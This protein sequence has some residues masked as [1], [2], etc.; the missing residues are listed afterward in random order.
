MTT[1]LI[2]RDKVLR[3]LDGMAEWPNGRMSFRT[4]ERYSKAELPCTTTLC[5]PACCAIL[6]GATIRYF[7][8]LL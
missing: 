6:A 4:K 8:R 2:D 7:L 1:I 3:L 5:M